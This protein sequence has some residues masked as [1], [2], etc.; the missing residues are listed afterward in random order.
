MKSYVRIDDL[1]KFQV[2]L[3]QTVEDLNLFLHEKTFKTK[4]KTLDEKLD[5]LQLT[6]TNPK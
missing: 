3:E 4:M 5:Q 2:K 6:K 1:N